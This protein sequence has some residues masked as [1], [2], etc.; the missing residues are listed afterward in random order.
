M[1]QVGHSVIYATPWAESKN[2]VS[3]HLISSGTNAVDASQIARLRDEF[4]GIHT[5]RINV[6]QALKRI[7]SE[8]YN[9]IY[10]YQLEDYLLQYVNRSAL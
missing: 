2:P 10:I 1:T 3:T 6:D 9:N 8:A 4:R 7:I 5:D